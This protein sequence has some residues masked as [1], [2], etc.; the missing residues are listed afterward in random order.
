MTTRNLEKAFEA[1]RTLPE[2]DQNLVASVVLSVVKHS[3]GAR[4]I[5]L[6]ELARRVSREAKRRGMT[7]EIF[8]EIMADA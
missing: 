1:A 5:D 7:Q 4:R 3:K 6:D 8:D 2:K